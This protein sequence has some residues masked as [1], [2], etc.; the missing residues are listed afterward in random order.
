M[1]KIQDGACVV[2]E[3]LRFDHKTLTVDWTKPKR[4][5]ESQGSGNHFL[6][7][8]VGAFVRLHFQVKGVLKIV[9]ALLLSLDQT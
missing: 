3:D 7:S 8:S 5:S 4:S 1:C 9:F 2:S 6:S